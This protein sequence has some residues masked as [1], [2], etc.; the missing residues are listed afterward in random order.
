VIRRLSLILAALLGLS[1]VPT[2]SPSPSASSAAG[3]R[4]VTITILSL[5]SVTIPHD[6]APK[7]RENK[8]DW[9]DYK[10]LLVTTGPLF[11]KQRKNQPVG[12]EAG[13]QTFTSATTA[14]LKSVV[15]F[16][17]QGTIRVNGDMK[18][19]ANGNTSVRIVGGTGKFTGAQG[20]LVI[21]PGE[22][23]SINTYHL[24]LPG[25]SVA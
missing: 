12:F 1:A 4:K 14:R 15:T 19:M 16:P 2:A 9:V 3:N 24:S 10:A 5:T 7:G 25:A 17:G 11:G 22:L 21:G 6:T 13:R 20:V 18:D 8:G 23:R